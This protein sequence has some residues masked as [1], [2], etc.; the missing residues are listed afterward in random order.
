SYAALIGALERTKFASFASNFEDAL[1]LHQRLG[2]MGIRSTCLFISP[3]P[4]SFFRSS[5][6][7]YLSALRSRMEQRSRSGD[8]IANKLAKAALYREL[9]LANESQ[10]PYVDNSAGCL[11][12]ALQDINS[13]V[14]Q[15]DFRFGNKEA[16]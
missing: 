16:T 4:L 1:P 8:R 12:Q 2:A 11:Q 10:I 15:S 13:I 14:V 3:V 7:E 6:D 5:P 9:Y